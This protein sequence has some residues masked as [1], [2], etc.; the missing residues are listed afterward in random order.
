MILRGEKNE[1]VI[2]IM[3]FNLDKCVLGDIFLLFFW[4]LLILCGF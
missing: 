2:E 4:E 1:F 3:I